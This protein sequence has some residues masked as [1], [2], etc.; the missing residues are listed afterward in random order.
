MPIPKTVAEPRPFDIGTIQE[1][2]RLD[3]PE[4]APGLSM[5]AP[6][7]DK[8][9]SVI[10]H[11]GTILRYDHD[12]QLTGSPVFLEA[13]RKKDFRSRVLANIINA[14]F[15]KVNDELRYPSFTCTDPEGLPTCSY[16]D[17]LFIDSLDSKAV[18]IVSQNDK[19]ILLLKQ[20]GV[21]TCLTLCDITIDGI[22]YPAGSIARPILTDEAVEREEAAKNTT[23]HGQYDVSE[24]TSLG[25]L[26]LSIFSLPPSERSFWEKR[27]P[28]KIADRLHEFSI[29]TLTTKA[30]Q[31][32]H[33]NDT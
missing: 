17:R 8:A 19:P 18:D 22:P 14:G 6:G 10:A 3:T 7:R 5:F 1:I 2:E 23:S 20:L 24:L 30:D 9:L 12:R 29:K 32:L 15:E 26:R 16:A 33:G 28:K 25:F 21:H 11:A 27:Y 4:D 13:E 31:I